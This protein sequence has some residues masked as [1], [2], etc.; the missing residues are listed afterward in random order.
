MPHLPR[1]GR[2][3]NSIPRLKHFLSNVHML[4]SPGCVCLE[5]KYLMP[6]KLSWVNAQGVNCAAEWAGGSALFGLVCHLQSQKEADFFFLFPGPR[7]AEEWWLP[8][9]PRQ[10]VTGDWKTVLETGA[11]T[12]SLDIK[13]NGYKSYILSWS[14]SGSIYLKIDALSHH[15]YYFERNQCIGINYMRIFT[16]RL[17]VMAK[18]W[19]QLHIHRQE[20]SWRTMVSRLRNIM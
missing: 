18:H 4:P 16:V 15:L 7:T 20:I 14:Q 9:E 1:H 10:R 17:F 8:R 12:L 11:P 6:R 2:T 5:G 19:K 3:L 13:E